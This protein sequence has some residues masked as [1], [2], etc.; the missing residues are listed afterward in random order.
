MMTLLH[1][2]GG[3]LTLRLMSS[4]TELLCPA[5]QSEIRK[6]LSMS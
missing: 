6:K 2:T 1:K 4:F 5:Q 3:V